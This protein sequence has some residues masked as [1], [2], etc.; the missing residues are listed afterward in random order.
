MNNNPKVS[1][2]VPIYNV[3]NYMRPMLESVRNQRFRDFEVILVND[4]SKDGSQQIIDEYCELD[5]RFIGH[6][7]ENAGVS[8]A[9]NTGIGLAKG[10][11]IAFYDPDDYVPV[12]ALGK[13]YRRASS[14]GADM[15]IGV[16]V[17]Q[18]LGEK[19]I[20]QNSQKL[21]KQKDI[22][23]D[24]QHFFKA[25]AI[26]HKLFRRQFLLDNNLKYEGFIN[27][28]D[29]VFTYCC[30]NKA[31]K[32]TGC[33]VVAY[34]YYKRPFWETP[35]ATQIVSNRYLEGLL[36]SHKRIM[37]EA[38]KISNK[39][40]YLEPLY[41]RYIENE[42][43]N[44]YYR[45]IW[46]AE[47]D[48]TARLQ[49]KTDEYRQHITE[50]SWNKLLRRHWDLELENGFMT[51]EEL[52][53]KP[54]LSILLTADIDEDKL[55]LMIGSIFNQAFSRFEL[56][57]DANIKHKVSK[58]YLDK[59]NVKGC[60]RTKLL[61]EARGEYVAILDEYLLYTR[62]SLELMINRLHRNK[63]L[64]FVSVLIKQYDGAEY[65]QLPSISAEYNYV[66]AMN[67]FVNPA[68]TC[69]VFVSNK[70]FRK[71]SISYVAIPRDIKS[72]VKS[73]YSLLSFDKLRKGV[74]ITDMSDAEVREHAG[75]AK[76]GLNTVVMYATNEGTR[77]AIEK[78]KR[79]I[80]RE[81]I[82]RLLKR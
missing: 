51:Q 22:R 81:D 57:I 28:E 38:R 16:A 25:W 46:R 40:E 73:E 47:S 71:N 65:K 66:K 68:A 54:I 9:R 31:Q 7:Q 72:F 64:D 20:Y 17:E 82:D 42:L 58:A 23:P 50:E 10:E 44:G 35:S 67:R 60:A 62:R 45:G 49:E 19:I 37:E 52:N 77:R 1:V 74:M 75:L 48:M 33:D 56:L 13:M 21:A 26:W 59:L 12:D 14:T 8:A 53:K 32:I 76:A 6:Y 36:A 24:D 5:D 30:L 79:L 3:E 78:V 27:A 39:A 61:E 63:R 15:V 11:Y 34:E 18:S 4:G 55:N 70:V 29:G 41:V 80:T 43:I 2:I 69:D